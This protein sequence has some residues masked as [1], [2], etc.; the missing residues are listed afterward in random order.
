MPMASRLMGASPRAAERSRLVGRG[1]AAREESAGG[2][3]RMPTQRRSRRTMQRLMGVLQE[4]AHPRVERGAMDPGVH[5]GGGPA[6][7]EELAGPGERANR[8]AT[9]RRGKG[10]NHG[11]RA[12]R[13]GEAA[14]GAAT[15]PRTLLNGRAAPHATRLRSA[16]VAAAPPRE[17]AAAHPR[18]VR[19]T[20]AVKAALQAAQLLAVPGVTPAAAHAAVEG[21]VGAGG[22]ASVG[23]AKARRPAKTAPKRGMEAPRRARAAADA[24]DAAGAGSA[25]A[26]AAA[27]AASAAAAKAA[28]TAAMERAAARVLP[29]TAEK[30]P[31]RPRTGGQWWSVSKV[32][33]SS[34]SAACPWRPHSRC[35]RPPSMSTGRSWRFS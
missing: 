26:A 5:G 2:A 24:I 8:G 15:R 3:G 13:A 32:G 33:L 6:S 34:L 12:S 19:A 10:V 35:C 25:A 16:A 31:T 29:A 18:P 11:E 9:A 1:V 27:A 7:R 14:T 4:A 21:S 17:R 28:V 22:I 20:A 30:A 23:R